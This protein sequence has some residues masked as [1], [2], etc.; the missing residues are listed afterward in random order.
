[1]E[2]W[3]G[4]GDETVTM[5][6][7]SQALDLLRGLIGEGTPRKDHSLEDTLAAIPQSRLG[8][9]RL[10]SK[11][12]RE[13]LIHAHGQSLPDWIALRCGTL[14]RYPDGVA[15]PTTLQDV[16][17]I[18]DYTQREHLVVIPYG[19]GTS[20]VGHLT[21]PESDRPVVSL[22]MKRLKRMITMEPESLLATFE[23]GVRGPDLEAQLA[24]K[25]YTFGH[26][27]QSFEYSSLGGWIVT[28]SSGQQS[29]HYGSIDRLFVG[30]EV[31][32]PRG[33]LPMT[34]FP[35]SAAGPDLKQL[36]L[37]SEGRMGV[38]TKA[39]VKITPIPEVDD[40]FGVFFPDWTEAF[41][42]VRNLAAAELPLSMIRLSN[43]VETMTNLYLAGHEREIALLKKYLSLRG[44][45]ENGCCMCL[46][47][48]I[49]SRRIA[50]AVK[51]EVNSIIGR[52]GAVS[53]GR[54]MGKGW[55]K[56]R[57]RT[58]YLRNTLWD[59]GYAVDT[60]ETSVPWDRVEETMDEIERVIGKGLMP[61]DENVHVFT[62]LSRIYATGSSIYTQFVFRLG[63]TPE[64]TV[65]RWKILKDAASRVIVKVGGTI[66]HQHGVGI[67]H[68]PYLEAE[69]GSVGM[70]LLKEITTYLDPERRMNP[71]K[72]I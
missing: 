2:R 19:G 71:T 66:S 16:K 11:D 15:H 58:P 65:E 46:I 63:E 51:G 60:L 10:I 38:L 23:A 68:K 42:G 31:I 4:W 53:V 64:A 5:E 17:E 56:N 54:S 29:L 28:R 18:L 22:S 21:I 61:F 55:K 6:L 12:P 45:P 69:K 30:G 52:H 40:V 72:L 9:Y 67:D 33:I 48:I 43:P 39:M 49:G 1:M 34:D 8:E 50:R 36:V 41:E 24:A 7:P 3:N 35:V 44:I 13:R 25:G 57:F 20:V 47:G 32:T 37:G 62:H 26:Y 70:G 27:P 14:E 59:A